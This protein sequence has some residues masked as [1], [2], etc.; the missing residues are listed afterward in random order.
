M[1]GWLASIAKERQ[2]HRQI[3]AYRELAELFAFFSGYHI[4][5]FNESAANLFDGFTRI[6]IGTMDRKIA[7]IAMVH[8]ALL[9]TRN[10][11]DFEQIPGLRFEN[12]MDAGTI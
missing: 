8:N 12:W 1:R 4:A 7:A 2:A 3:M 11:Q 5:L 6:R 10:R 9:L